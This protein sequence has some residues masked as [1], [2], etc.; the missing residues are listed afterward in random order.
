MQSIT[1]I[2]NELAVIG[3]PM[4]EEDKVVAL[5]ASL[6]DKYDMLVTALEANSEVPS[7]EVVTERL[8]SQNV[9]IS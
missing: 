2:F 5:L 8:S 4:G 6:P 9:R 1:E 3:A 7:M